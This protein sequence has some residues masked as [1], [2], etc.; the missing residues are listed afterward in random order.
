MRERMRRMRQQLHAALQ[1]RFEGRR[2]FEFLVRQRGMFSYTGL[3]AAQVERLRDEHGI[4]LV[5]SGRLCVSGL[6]E[7]NVA[8]VAGSIASLYE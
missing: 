2:S 7:R 3:A 6:S 8:H 5:G 4:Y 1:A